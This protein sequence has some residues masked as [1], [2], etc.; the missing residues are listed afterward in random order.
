MLLIANGLSIPGR[1]LSG[2]VAQRCLGAINTFCF[3]TCIL[4]ILIFI[5][6]AVWTPEVMYAFSA[7]I[8]LFTG[9]A[10]G[11]YNG[12]LSNLTKD[13]RRFGIRFGMVNTIAA[14]GALA[15]PPV[16][17]AIID[18]DGGRYRYAQVWAGVVLFLASMLFMA[19]GV[20]A[21]GRGWKAWALAFFD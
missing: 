6:L 1:L 14:I 18:A 20:K 8:G 10:Q 9:A 4:S 11:I 19:A 15:G 2:Y 12:A 13:P 17:G 3:T 5:W 16:A 21:G 7:L